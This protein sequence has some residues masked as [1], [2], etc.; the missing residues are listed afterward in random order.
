MRIKFLSV[1]IS[2]LLV[3]ISITSCLDSEEYAY[4][5]DATIHAF[6]IDSIKG[7]YHSFTIDQLNRHIYNRDSFPVGSDTILDCIYLDTLIVTGW[8]THADT[9][10]SVEDSVNLTA[11]I[12]CAPGS[13]M[14][15]KAYAADGITSRE[16]T[17]S[18]HVHLQEPDSLVWEDMQLVAPVFSAEV[19]AG[20]QKSV[21]LADELLVYTAPNKAYSTDI[22][23]LSLAG[24][25]YG[26]DDEVVSGLP[27][28]A[29]LTT[30]LNFSEVLYMLT[31][32][33]DIYSSTDGRNWEKNE[34]L[35]GNMVSLLGSLPANDVSDMEATLMGICKDESGVNTFCLT[36][37]ATTWTLGE[38][39]PI[40]FPTENIYS[41]ALINANGVG[42]LVAV[43]MPL[44]N[45]TATTPWF[46]MDGEGWASLETTSFDAYCPAMENPSIIYYGGS[47]Y[48]MGGEFD[49]IYKSVAGIAWEAT[50]E[51]FMLPESFE[52]K[53]SYSLTV[54][55]ENYIWIVWGGNGTPN[56]V[57]RGRLNRLGFAIQ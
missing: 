11:A 10:V 49:A 13:G 41:S 34:N 43:G 55:K 47:Y 52:G 38:E 46:T 29:K 56:E 7:V 42:K 5:T 8:V 14:K 53:G 20:E 50:E 25:R 17:L 21:I 44:A 36:T 16:Y 28:D 54:D 35:S 12:N 57:W 9:L 32:S 1:I 40:G 19:N 15:F 51:M 45:E 39:V 2:F 3:S 24:A 37:D 18:V 26:W 33:G 23:Y 27:A 30:V 48:M 22:H 31:E 6:G 4:S